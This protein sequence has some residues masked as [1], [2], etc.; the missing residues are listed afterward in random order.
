[1]IPIEYIGYMLGLIGVWVG[2]DG[3]YSIALYINAPSFREG[4]KQSWGKD[5]AIRIIR[6][7]CGIAL[8]FFGWLLV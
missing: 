2:S 1:M 3:A 5:H 8:I 4:E 7:I 6:I